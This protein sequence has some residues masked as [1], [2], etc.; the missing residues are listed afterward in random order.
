MPLLEPIKVT[1]QVTA[2][3]ER[4][5][6]PYFIG[7]SLASTLYGTVRSTQDSDIVA[8]L[9]VEKVPA[10][11]SALKDDF[12]VDDQMVADAVTGR[13]S[14]NIIHRESMFK[15]DVFVS[16]NRRFEQTQFSRSRKVNLSN[17]PKRS[18]VFCSPEDILLAKMEW[19]RMGGEISERQWRDI[20]DVLKVQKNSLDIDYLNTMANELGVADLL[21]RALSQT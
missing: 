1:L 21:E 7:G 12:Y 8:E 14:F 2:V 19:Y 20:D 17:R 4:L 15:V 9:S 6:V 18:A 11:V 5:A 16:R 10:F 13:T 3:F